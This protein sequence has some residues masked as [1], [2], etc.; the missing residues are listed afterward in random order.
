MGILAY[1][2]HLAYFGLF[3]YIYIFL[4]RTTPNGNAIE[5][6][7]LAEKKKTWSQCPNAG[8]GPVGDRTSGRDVYTLWYCIHTHYGMHIMVLYTHYGMHIVVLYTHFGIDLAPFLTT[9]E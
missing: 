5:S 6:S 7:T 2:K 3:A 4:A 8:V 9:V 1:L